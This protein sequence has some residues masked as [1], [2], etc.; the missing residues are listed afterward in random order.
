MHCLPDHGF[1]L[2]FPTY[3]YY[4]VIFANKPWK[5]SAW[6]KYWLKAN[7][8]LVLFYHNKIQT[9]IG[10]VGYSRVCVPLSVPLS[11]IMLLERISVEPALQSPD[12]SINVSE[13][14]DNEGPSIAKVGTGLDPMKLVH[15]A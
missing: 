10:T 9:T 2:C 6:T 1:F 15:P 7:Y 8:R 11:A 3:T 4:L 5:S 14:Y 12:D 13:L